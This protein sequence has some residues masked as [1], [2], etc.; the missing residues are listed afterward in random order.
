MATIAETE[1]EIVED[2]AMFDQ[3]D[4]KYQYIIDLGKTLAPMNAEWKTDERLIKGCQ[5]RVWLYTELKDGK[6]IYHADSD[7]IITKGIVALMVRVLSG[8]TPKEIVDAPLDFIEKIGLKEH[9]SPTRANG[10]LS[11]VKQMKLDA[12]ALTAKN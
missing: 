11:M 1:N 8:H 10:L 6:V 5:S 2:F 12:L 7:A 9:L 3:W 4:D